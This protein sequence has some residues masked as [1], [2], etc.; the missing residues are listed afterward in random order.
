MNKVS[1]IKSFLTFETSEP[2]IKFK[3]HTKLYEKLM[4]NVQNEY[5]NYHKQQIMSTKIKSFVMMDSEAK[6]DLGCKK[7]MKFLAEIKTQNPV[8]PFVI[9]QSA[10]NSSKTK[11]SNIKMM[12]FVADTQSHEH[13]YQLQRQHKIWW[14]EI[15]TS[16]DKYS[17]SDQKIDD[18]VTHV[19]FRSSIIE[20]SLELE[21]L[22]LISLKESKRGKFSFKV[23]NRNVDVVPDVIE[24][25]F[26]LQNSSLAI[27]LDADQLS[28]SFLALYRRFA[29]YQFAIVKQN[30]SNRDLIDLARFIE[31]LIRE[32][33]SSIEVLNVD[34]DKG[35]DKWEHY[36][37]IGIPY[38][39]FLEESSLEKG[40]LK[41]RSR[42]TTLSESIHVSDIPNYLI[43]IIKS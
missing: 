40:I 19:C 5:Q 36:D 3:N 35:S 31:L 29:P 28:S 12:H 16:P 7:F 33:D 11:D 6:L 20:P 21:K 41:L 17:I 14:R 22:S 26:S 10:V 1:R 9:L 34:D 37:Q 15:G 25:S 43:K 2:S 23:S 8:L 39:I 38:C 4:Q 18:G 27:L 42:N 32:T 24:S 13:F 30:G